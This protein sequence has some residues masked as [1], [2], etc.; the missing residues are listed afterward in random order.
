[1]S[2]PRIPDEVD[3]TSS[4]RSA[5]VASRIGLWLGICFGLAFVTGVISHEA[6]VTH[7]LIPFP[8]RPSWGYRVTQGVHV[9]AGTAA[10]PLLLVKLWAVYP[11]LFARPPRNLRKLALDGLERVRRSR[12]WSPRRSSSSPP[13]C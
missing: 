12:C 4:L 10:I 7:P 5:P 9:L 6:Y 13:G 3:F 2:R 8:A 11:K 1:M